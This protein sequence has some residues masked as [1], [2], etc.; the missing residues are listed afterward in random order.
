MSTKPSP[1]KAA[2]AH[3]SSAA[4]G[5]SWATFARLTGVVAV[6][7]PFAV[8]YV[9]WVNSSWQRDAQNIVSRA[10]TAFKQVE[11]AMDERR[12]AS[13]V[14]PGAIQDLTRLNGATDEM[15]QALIKDV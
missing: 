14:I 4:K 7:L 1:P 5:F 10:D 2:A 13:L 8:Q 9:S 15:S 11:T 6:I 3:S 12:Y